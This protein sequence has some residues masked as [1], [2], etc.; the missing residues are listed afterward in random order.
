MLTIAV[1]EARPH[2]LLQNL[3]AWRL[4]AH[5]IGNGSKRI[6]GRSVVSVPQEW[7]SIDFDKPFAY[8]T[9]VPTVIVV[10]CRMEACPSS[11]LLPNPLRI[12]ETWITDAG[13]AQLLQHQSSPIFRMYPRSALCSDV[14][15]IDDMTIG[16]AARASLSEPYLFDPTEFQGQ[17]YLGGIVDL[18][19]IEL[20]QTLADEVVLVKLQPMVWPYED[21]FQS[22]FRYSQKNRKA[23]VD[24]QPV[25]VRVDLSDK[26]E[27][28]K[29]RSFWFGVRTVRVEADIQAVERPELESDRVYWLPRRR[30]VDAVPEDHAEFVQHVRAQYLYGYRRGMEAFS[31]HCETADEPR[32]HSPMNSTPQREVN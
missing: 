21:M 23:F 5:G 11:G 10:A 30:I 25:T 29:D 19:P 24:A 12:R 2:K 13:T 22:V 15:V 17:H 1:N 8:A 4:N 26:D 31:H 28:L 18:F 20:A 9:D 14:A 27:A 3:P 16:K 32:Q 6:L 7:N